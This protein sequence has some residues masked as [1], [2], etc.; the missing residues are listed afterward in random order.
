M[1][2]EDT[3]A[4]GGGANTDSMVLLKGDFNEDFEGLGV[5]I[6]ISHTQ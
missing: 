5:Y 2:V 4:K 3:L 1:C 6:Y